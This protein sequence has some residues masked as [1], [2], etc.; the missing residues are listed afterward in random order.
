MISIRLKIALG[1]LVLLIPLVII[2]YLFISG[3]TKV[4]NPLKY[5]IPERIKELRLKSELDSTALFIRYYDEVL[6]QS[7]RNYAFTGDESWKT[8]YDSNVPK[9]DE[10]IKNCKTAPDYRTVLEKSIIRIFYK[11][12]F[13]SR[14]QQLKKDR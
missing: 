5:E 12:I 11:E 4:T 6:T 7:A 1:F 2:G 3:F 8:R 10:M 14:S 9:L 13:G